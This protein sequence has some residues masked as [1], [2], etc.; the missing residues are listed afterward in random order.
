MPSSIA[1]AAA[2]AL[3][4]FSAP[5]A[6]PASPVQAASPAQ[7]S[8]AQAPVTPTPA[9]PVLELRELL[10]VQDGAVVV[11]PRARQLAGQQ[12]RV[13][14][15]LVVF[16]D[17]PGDGFWLAP[18]PVFQDES[19]AG[20]GELPPSALRVTAP[21]VVLSALPA[22]PVPLEVTGTL[23]LDRETDEQGRIAVARVHVDDPGSVRRLE[24]RP[25]PI[26]AAGTSSPPAAN[27]AGK[28]TEENR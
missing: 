23:R 15:W 20:S 21:A 25:S 18:R 17:A 9:I 27:H 28:T 11:A 22:S 26:P 4:T 6:P 5:S 3:A 19:G 16:E 13:R 10:A 8:A 7:A 1:L 12:V 24:R 14:G 2:A